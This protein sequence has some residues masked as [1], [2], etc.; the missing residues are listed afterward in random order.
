MSK[1][2]VIAI[3]A[4]SAV[5]LLGASLT[6]AMDRGKTGGGRPYV[7][8][9]IGQQEIR[10]LDAE[11][12][13]YNLWLITAAKTSGAYLADVQLRITNAKKHVVF[14][15]KLDGP[16]LLV[17]LPLG[18]FNIEATYNGETYHKVT[19]ISKG[20]HREIVFYFEVQADVLPE[21]NAS[22]QKN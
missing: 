8:G 21:G 13:K 6:H 3:C 15:R 19:T 16:W 10:T 2:R 20:S 1:S 12:D 18:T 22:S 11:R 9:G 14:E 5:A 7:V 17:D 4:L